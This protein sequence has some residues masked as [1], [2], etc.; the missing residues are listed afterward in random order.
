[1]NPTLRQAAGSLLVVGL[2]NTELT[3]LERA[4]LKLIRPGGIILFRRNITDAQQTRALLTEA[5]G[6]CTPAPLRCVDV[7]GGTVDRLR[8]AVAPMPSSKSVAQSRKPHLMR[9]HGQLVAQEILAFGFNTTLAPVFDL[10]LPESSAILGS[11]AAGSTPQAVTE[12]A[13]E[14]LHGL[15]DNG[16]TGCAKHFPGL[17]GGTVDSHLH[18]PA[19]ERTF[20]EI[21]NQDLAPYR[22]LIRHLP[23]VMVTHAAYPK[24]RSKDKPATASEFWIKSILQSRMQYRG[25]I[26][27]DDLE[28]GGILKY[29]PI[30]QA[31][32][33]AIRA[34]MH[35][36]EICH[37]PEIIL[38]AYES[39][40]HEAE[41]S[42]AFRNLLLAR[43][44]SSERLRQGRFNQPIPRALTATQMT[45]LQSR[46][47][48]FATRV[49]AAQQN[50]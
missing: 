34:G 28:M 35:L 4:W 18:T 21:W 6:Y 47:C 8:D 36:L 17:G 7:E 43:A 1:M 16:V 27:S 20:S 42:T 30:E 10:G 14:F 5:T 25:L 46:V 24:T 9:R 26:F 22:E 13:G 38:F 44:R 49:R 19:I 3:P 39:L 50:T 45:A 12:Y 37:S 48:K 29:L 32:V 31:A 2:S 40:L 33:A 15:A 11:R 23:M 41:R